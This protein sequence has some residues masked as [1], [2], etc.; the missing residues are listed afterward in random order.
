MAPSIISLA[1][2]FRMPM[3]D[4]L[5]NGQGIGVP[6]QVP[7]FRDRSPEDNFSLWHWM[8]VSWMSPLIATAS[9]RQLHDEDV[10]LLP[11]QFQHERLHHLFRQVKGSVTIRILKANAPDL[12]ITSALGILESAT[13]LLPIVLLKQLL[14]ALE[15]SRP[16]VRVAA[17][18]AI[19]TL[20]NNLVSA[21]CGVFSLWFSRRCY[22]RSRGEMITMVYEKTLRRKAFTIPSDAQESQESQ[23]N[24]NASSDK[25][26]D[27][28]PA[29]GPASMGKILNIMRNDVYEVAQRFWEFPSLLTRPLDFILSIVLLW[30][31]LGPASLLGIL[32]LLLA[33]FLNYF[34]IRILFRWEVKRRSITDV[35]LQITS[36]FIEAIR[37]LRWYDWQDKWLGRIL[38]QRHKELQYRVITSVLSKT[39][40]VLNEAAASFFPVAAFYAYTVIGKQP[41]TVEVAF[42]A[43]NLFNLLESSLQELPNLVTVLLNAAVAMRRIEGF[44]AEPD[45][46]DGHGDDAPSQQGELWVG[47]SDASFAWPGLKHCVLKNVSLQLTPGLTMVCGKVGTGKTAL[48]QA[49]LGELDQHGGEKAIPEEMV[50]YCAQT[51][52]LQSMSIRENILFCQPFEER[53]YRRVLDACCLLQ[54]LREFKAGDLSLIGENGIG[55][56]GG[57]RAR[58]ALARAVYSRSRITL[59]DD[60]IAALDHNTAETIMKKLFSTSDLMKDRLTIFVTHRV[61]LVGKYASSVVEVREGGTVSCMD[62]EA[63]AS[64]EELLHRVASAD[65]DQPEDMS[66]FDGSSDAIPDKFI[67]EEYRAHGGVMASVYWRY[68][69]AGKL[70]WWACVILFFVAFRFAKVGYFYFLKMWGEGYE[71]T[72]ETP[73]LFLLRPGSYEDGRLRAAAAAAPVRSWDW[74]DNIDL[75]LPRP[76]ENVMPWLFW[77]AMLALAQLVARTASDVVTIIITYTAGKKVFD[78]VMHRVSNATF[79]FFDVTPVGRLM[80]RVTSDIGTVDGQIASQIYSVLWFSL[81]WTSAMVVIATAAPV[82]LVLALFMT[83]TFVVIFL[84][85]LPASQSL[86]RLEMVSL[87][88]LMSNFGALVEGL[89]TVRAFRAQHHFQRHNIATTDAFQKMDHFYWSLQAWLQFRF[90]MLSAL[91]T[92]ALTATALKLGLS[93]GVVAFVLAAAANFVSSTHRLC[94]R[95]GELQMQFVSVERVVELLDLEQEKPGDRD[96]PAAVS[97]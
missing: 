52:W 32:V 13:A 28:K 1:I 6:S 72:S 50:G 49:I 70:R 66:S 83:V 3:R 53:R 35:K 69:K 94:R 47:L 48:L 82:F 85:F 54:D 93:S 21:Q 36:Q 77:F 34:V 86:R 74:S 79:R 19:L 67:E 64:D 43:L 25:S 29:D 78:D 97:L 92:F 46:E 17:V 5:W 84:R 38:T 55:L 30:K 57:Q 16:N 8:T 51:P 2:M 26:K 20:C 75:G 11:Y 12:F 22:E 10:W 65:N 31:I 89:V 73:G 42:P 27:Q 18:Y 9:K 33:Q 90:D 7:S 87:S 59:L 44:M 76:D 14:S 41:L 4:P 81:N 68:V 96:P 88:P 60:P 45:K 37:H 95:Y 71:H 15:G 56:S 39:I 91:S 63:L 61:D 62:P 58:V 80:N 40:D 24:G 23:A